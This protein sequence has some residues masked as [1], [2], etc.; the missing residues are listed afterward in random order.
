MPKRKRA[1][2]D[3]E[4]RAKK[5]SFV[6]FPPKQPPK[7][8]K[9]SAKRKPTPER[10]EDGYLCFVDYPDFHPNLTPKEVLQ[11]GSFGGTYFRDIS[12]AV[13]GE[14]HLGEDQIDEFP[15][16][17][18][19]GLDVKTQ[20]C[21]QVYD[22]AVNKYGVRCGGGLDMWETSGWI[23]QQDPYGWF[24]WYCHFYL[25]RRSSD[26]RR[27]VSRG[28]KC[29]GPKGRWR[30]N[31]IG[32]CARAGK[33]FDDY[34]V[35]P[36]VR[37]ALQHW[38]YVLNENDANDY[39]ALKE[40]PELPKALGTDPNSMFQPKKDKGKLFCPNTMEKLKK[41]AKHVRR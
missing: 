28:L 38:G 36:V 33:A 16:D 21:S 7:K 32:K 9:S 29:F 11:R 25:G 20:V 8:G 34:T 6:H 31:L 23:N 19:D 3:A 2:Y 4:E 13:T 15:L 27:Q 26:D 40:L 39:V 24:Q 1:E 10:D 22:P 41:I 35:S 18:M 37:Q 12:S 17:W 30:N 5:K 14:D